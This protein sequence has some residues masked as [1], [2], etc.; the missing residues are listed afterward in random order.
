VGRIHEWLQKILSIKA[1]L[2]FFLSFSNLSLSLVTL[3]RSANKSRKKELLEIFTCSQIEC[4]PWGKGGTPPRCWKLNL[5][6]IPFLW[7][8]VWNTIPSCSVDHLHIVNILFYI[9]Y[10][11]WMELISL[12]LICYWFLFAMLHFLFL[13]L[14]LFFGIL[15][16]VSLVQGFQAI[17]KITTLLIND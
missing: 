9:F 10:L 5:I 3:L 4:T 8:E 1:P 11:S 17:F 16:I 14:W 6:W 7:H 15:L 13:F 2:Y 12:S